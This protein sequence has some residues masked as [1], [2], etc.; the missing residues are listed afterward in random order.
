MDSGKRVLTFKP[1]R[2]TKLFEGPNTPSNMTKK[3]GQQL[4]Q[5][6]AP[7]AAAAAA[8]TAIDDASAAVTVVDM[9]S[10]SPPYTVV[11]RKKNSQDI[12]NFLQNAAGQTGGRAEDGGQAANTPSKRGR[13][14]HT[15]PQD[16]QAKRMTQQESEEEEDAFVEAQ[17]DTL[18]GRME[19]M[20]KRI[21]ERAGLSPQQLRLVMEVVQQDLREIVQV[22][23]REAATAAAKEATKTAM[24]AAKEAANKEMEAD[25]CRRS[26]LIHNADRWVPDMNNGLTIA[27]N[28]T[29]QIHRCMSH[30]V[31]VLDAF[32]IGQWQNNRPPTSV[33]VTFGSPAQKATFFKAL[34]RV[35]ADRKAGWEMLKGISCRDAFPR[36]L[37]NESKRLAQK[38]FALR[39]NGKIAAFRVVARGPSCIPVLEVRARL[40]NNASGRWEVFKTTERPQP[41][42]PMPG[43][44]AATQ[45]ATPAG[46]E[47]EERR[48]EDIRG[49]KATP[50]KSLANDDIVPLGMEEE[51][52]Y[53]EPF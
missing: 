3:N 53:N 34:A 32:A 38:G 43:T 16:Q 45:K 36:A 28:V 2:L 12:R 9:G 5:P 13:E 31:C 23:T 50:R 17:E 44:E 39:Q 4:P 42:V 20:G 37:V 52:F 15:P 26:I 8:A 7:A 24:A 11:G 30:T 35:I 46:R 22:A 27:E 6:D 1:S 49:R 18:E 29:A 33:F 25:R 47:N 10:K 41:V 21:M 51:E 19:Q 14:E 48:G 40:A